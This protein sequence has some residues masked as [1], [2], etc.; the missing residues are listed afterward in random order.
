[1]DAPSTVPVQLTLTNDEALVLFEWLTRT[2]DNDA[3]APFVDRAEQRV[4]WDLLAMLERVLVGPLSPEY[5]K[6]LTAARAALHDV[7][8]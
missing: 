4:L 1:V 6:L 3:P 7:G 2:S 5:D 8:S